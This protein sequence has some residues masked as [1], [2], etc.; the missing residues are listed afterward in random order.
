MGRGAAITRDA[1]GRPTQIISTLGAASRTTVLRYDLA[2][3]DYNT[4]DAP[5]GSI[6]SLS[7][8]QDPE[9]TTRFQRDL[10]GRITRKTQILASGS[11]TIGYAYVP[12]GQN[13]AGQIAS[14]T[15]PSGK[16][17]TYAYDA[18]GRLTAMAW[19]GQP[20]VTG[21]T[22]SPLGQATAWQWPGFSARS[23]S[24]GPMA[25]TRAYTSAG[26]LS[27]SALL[28]LSWDAAGRVSRIQ[29]KHMLPA[30]SSG[31]GT[32]PQQTTL[33]SVYT[34]DPVGRLTASAH[35]APAALGL[36]SGWSLSDI[37]GPTT[38]GHAWDANGNR[39]Q[40]HY[41]FIAPS[42]TTT[43]QRVFK[44]TSG[45]NRLSGYTQTV[46]EPGAG[47]VVTTVAYNHDA[48]GALTKS[49]DNYLHYGVDGRMVK[50]AL[51]ADASQPA[52]MN[53]TYNALSQRLQK[54]DARTSTATPVVEQFAYADDGQGST[55]AG[56]YSNRR[57]ADSAAPAGETD[58]SEIIYLPTS[59]GPM[60][61][62]AQI[63]GRLYAID[64]DHLNTP[65]R[66]TNTQGQVAWQWLI[67]GFGEVQPT[68]GAKGFAL[69]GID[70]GRVYSPA[71]VFNLRY[72]GQQWDSETGLSYNMNRYYDAMTG[73]Y[74]TSD[75]I[76]LFGGW[77]RFA[78]AG[79]NPLG[80]ADP[81]GL[82]NPGMGPYAVGAS[83]Y[84]YAGGPGHI[85]IGVNGS[86][87]FGYYPTPPSK[88]NYEF[89]F[90]AF[91]VE[92][93]LIVIRRTSLIDPFGWMLVLKV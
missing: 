42:G 53:Y 28:T 39:T 9:V 26:Q 23:G 1:L 52:A 68:L 40:V 83:V 41:S 87:S 70:N 81:R 24:A 64:S 11:R 4:P 72:P 2:G 14:M 55:L 15:Y 8:I 63:N 77:N 73:R 33:A 34:Y 89:L 59:S 66:L 13:G 60:P 16:Q 91:R 49:G 6:G 54:T 17:L 25:E 69:N 51:T 86:S 19:A 85:G 84:Y 74:V 82:D 31:V 56:A 27:S 5:Q 47:A 37:I 30:A 48:A 79:G 90:P 80:Q 57:S 45:T 78:Y 61:V 21:L 10:Q 3:A 36:P 75:P 20:L 46:K 58:S 22:W 92:F 38:T 93:G 88:T 18:T 35:S 67:S 29:Q 71:V 43:Q 7:E 62:A 76:G 50:A 65:R 12:A 44:T 32:S